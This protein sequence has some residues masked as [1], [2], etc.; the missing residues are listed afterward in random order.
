MEPVKKPK[1]CQAG[2]V[3]NPTTGRCVKEKPTKPTKPKKEKRFP[4]V[5]E[6]DYPNN[7]QSKKE[8]LPIGVKFM[9][10]IKSQL[11]PGD[12]ITPI[13]GY[14][15]DGL[16]IVGKR[17]AA[18]LPIR[19]GKEDMMSFLPAWVLEMGMKNGFPLEKLI[20]LYAKDTPLNFLILPKSEQRDGLNIVGGVAKSVLV[21]SI[22]YGEIQV[23]K[24][25]FD[26]KDLFLK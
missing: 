11:Q 6:Y 4:K 17:G 14:D 23:E 16:I 15:I 12:I 10:G 19:F 22:E 8:L 7:L 18:V 24:V 2:K 25:D 20:K 9:K 26:A 21:Y 3:I 5:W 1:L 13:E